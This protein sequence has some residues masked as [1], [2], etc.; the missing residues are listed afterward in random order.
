MTSV[1]GF[2]RQDTLYIEFAQ[3]LTSLELDPT[4]EHA[5]GSASG[6]Q[7]LVLQS[8]ALQ[9]LSFVSSSSINAY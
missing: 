7:C 8:S 2:Q 5:F 4:T 3:M 6:D 1:A 9:V